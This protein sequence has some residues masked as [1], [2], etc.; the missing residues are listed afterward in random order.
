MNNSSSLGEASLWISSAGIVVLVSLAILAVVTFNPANTQRGLDFERLRQWPYL[1]CGAI[2]VILELVGLGCGFAARDTLAGKRGLAVSALV[3]FLVA[4]FLSSFGGS[5]LPS[6]ILAVAVFVLFT[7]TLLR[8][9]L[10]VGHN[11]DRVERR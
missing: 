1:L 3:W 5:P 2:F 10:P 4:S 6:L 9:L 7:L 8:R 11:A